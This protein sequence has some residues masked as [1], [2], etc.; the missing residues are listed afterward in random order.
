MI[1]TAILWDKCLDDLRYRVKD[2]VFTMWLRPLSV[3]KEEQTLIIRAPNDYFVTYI[4]KNHLADIEQLVI[5]HSQN[6]IEEVVVRVD[7]NSHSNAQNV[8]ASETGTID[9]NETSSTSLF[10]GNQLSPTLASSDN[11]AKDLN[12]KQQVNTSQAALIDS[13]DI[14]SLS[15][16]NPDFTFET[17]V[18][19]KS[20]NL[21][22]KACYELTKPQS[23]NRHNPLFIYGPSGLGKTHLMHSVAQRYLKNNRSFYYFTSEKFINQL[24]YSLRNNK[25]EDFKKKIKKVDL[26]I[27]DDIHVLA[28]K[29]KSSNEFLTLFADFTSGDKQLILAS[30]RHPSQ[31]T[32]FDERFRSRFSWGLTVAVEPP[33]IDTRV[34]I[35]QKKADSYGMLLPKE[36]ALFIAQNVVSNVRRLEGALNQVFA[37]ANLTGAPITLE[38]VQYALKDI[39][40]MR[41]QAVNMDNIRKVVAEYY[42]ITVKDLMGRKRTRTIARPRQI[43]MALSRELT[44][45]SYPDI[46]QSFGGRD[47]TTV[48]HGCDKVAELRAADPAF[49][50]D[51]KALAMMLQAG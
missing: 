5:K 3:H 11:N 31:M 1:D 38:M 16:L 36:C 17:F 24:V 40:A 43:A 15:Y 46:G 41:V 10:T 12:N 51:Y 9:N 19:G 28:G 26:L 29:T 35:L 14:K 37:N 47:H 6:S 4:K 39:V 20:N 22:Y 8:D 7:N 30:D 18:T 48:M 34:Q 23:K 45:D 21:A 25:I 50:K 13:A 33:E 49:D 27:V 32:E 44:G 42:D 2:N